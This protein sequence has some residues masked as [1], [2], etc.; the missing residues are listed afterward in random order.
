MMQ[1]LLIRYSYPNVKKTSNST[2]SLEL[3]RLQQ[4]QTI[5]KMEEWWGP[6]STSERDSPDFRSRSEMGR[7]SSADTIYCT[8]T[9]VP[10]SDHTWLERLIM[11]VMM[12][13]LMMFN[14]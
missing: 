2:D 9:P 7:L 1:T 13:V 10:T 14:R 5:S 11:E 8:P 3:E 6:I 4:N 12:V